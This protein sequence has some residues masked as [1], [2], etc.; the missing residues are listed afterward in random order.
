MSVAGT[1]QD[2]DAVTK[3]GWTLRDATAADLAGAQARITDFEA[4]VAA[5]I[6]DRDT[7]RERVAALETETAER[8]S[9]NEALNL[10]LASARE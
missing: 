8:A 7:A 2:G 6:L 1:G 4:Q 3:A 9:D 5:L 10:A